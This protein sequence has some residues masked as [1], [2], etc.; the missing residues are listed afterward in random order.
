MKS[1]RRNRIGGEYMAEQTL[2]HYGVEGMKWGVRR[3]QPYTQVG[4]GKTK[5][6]KTPIN[7][8]GLSQRD[9]NTKRKLMTSKTKGKKTIDVNPKAKAKLD[10][11]NAKQNITKDK[12]KTK[13]KKTLNTGK[14]DGKTLADNVIDNLGIVAVSS[15]TGG[16]LVSKGQVEVGA[17]IG[18]MGGMYAAGSMLGDVIVRKL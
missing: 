1:I 18:S 8:K 5:T 6:K 11:I 3:Y 7:T 16:Y 15:L 17:L 14:I 10:S 2:T 13:A 4:K 9:A 12:P